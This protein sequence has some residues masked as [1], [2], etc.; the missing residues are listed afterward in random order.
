LSA[1]LQDLLIHTIFF[2]AATRGICTAA[3]FYGRF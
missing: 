3:G 2:A 1:I